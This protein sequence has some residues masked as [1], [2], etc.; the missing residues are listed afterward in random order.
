MK[1][2]AII[3]AI[4][5]NDYNS[6]GVLKIIYDTMQEIGEKINIIDLSTQN[7][8]YFSNSF[9]HG[10]FS[11]IEKEISSS[12]GIIFITTSNL[13]APCAITQN[14]LE[15]LSQPVYKNT[16][17]NKNCMIVA[18]SNI[19]D[20]S[21][22]INYMSMVVNYLGGYDSVKIPLSYATTKSINEDDKLLIE[23]YTEDFYRYVKQNRRFFT[24]SYAS[25]KNTQQLVQP[26]GGVFQKPVNNN[27]VPTPQPEIFQPV[28]QPIQQPVHQPAQA[29]HQP[30]IQQ[31]FASQSQQSSG[32]DSF[33]KA[34]EDD[35]LEITR[36]LSDKLGK[37]QEPIIQQAPLHTQPQPKQNSF[38]VKDIFNNELTSYNVQNLSPTTLNAR[39]MTQNLTHY[40]QPHLAEGLVCNVELNITG[41]EAFDGVIVINKNTCEF[42]DGK[43]NNADVIISASDDAW[44]QIVNG[45]TS[46]QKSFMTGQIKVRGNFVLLSK[47]DNLFKI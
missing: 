42:V 31:P 37:P 45:T 7:L 12:D 36:T 2:T 16:L 14:F 35:I 30:Q 41:M 9:V 4:A 5:G 8:P 10:S 18:I 47:F 32:L 19:Q 1:I 38:G 11:S 15:H 29:Q 43:S 3:G 46:T 6:A 17:K 24:P 25:T 34:Q 28:Q 21:A 26:A 13:F 44:K 22:S 33:Y 39:Q 20:V 40:F 27:A 23:R